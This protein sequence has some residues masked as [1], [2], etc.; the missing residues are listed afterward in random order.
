MIQSIILT[1]KSTFSLNQESFLWEYSILYF[2][3]RFFF[4]QA[5]KTDAE[6]ETNS[7]NKE[8]QGGK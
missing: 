2:L 4:Q 6:L 3:W 8:S 7:R 5:F 1:T